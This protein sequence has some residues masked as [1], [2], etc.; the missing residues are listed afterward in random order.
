MTADQRQY[1][2]SAIDA[3]RRAALAADGDRKF[4]HQQV[5]AAA[6]LQ[7]MLVLSTAAGLYVLACLLV[8]IA[9]LVA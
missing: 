9:L 4:R 1:L 3:H 2:K 6:A 5:E 7:P 8:A